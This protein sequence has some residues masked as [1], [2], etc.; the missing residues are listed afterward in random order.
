MNLYAILAFEGKETKFFRDCSISRFQTKEDIITILRCVSCRPISEIRKKTFMILTIQDDMDQSCSVGVP[1]Q[2][3][4]PLTLEKV[5]GYMT[6]EEVPT[7]YREISTKVRNKKRKITGARK[8]KIP[9]VPLL[10]VSVPKKKGDGLHSK[11]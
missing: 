9:K 7:K 1:I 8:T 2:M 10:T 6:S 3:T 4:H 5:W 11:A